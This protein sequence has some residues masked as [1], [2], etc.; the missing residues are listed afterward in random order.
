MKIKVYKFGATFPSFT[1]VYKTVD[2]T[3]KGKV[4]YIKTGPLSKYA[5]YDNSY[6]PTENARLFEDV[7]EEVKKKAIEAIFWRKWE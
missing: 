4:L 6:L 1:F 7:P 5:F 3:K 2:Y